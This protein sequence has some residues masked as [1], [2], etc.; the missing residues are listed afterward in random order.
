MTD[1]AAAESAFEAAAHAADAPAAD[2]PAKPGVGFVGCDGRSRVLRV[3][4]V[5][6]NRQRMRV[7]C[8]HG[9]GIHETP[10]SMA[11]PLCDGEPEPELIEIPPDELERDPQDR[12]SGSRRISD[13]AL[14]DAIPVGGDVVVREVAE[15]VGYA[16]TKAG[17]TNMLARLRRM[18]KRSEKEGAPPPFVIAPGRGPRPALVRRVKP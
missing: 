16:K 3:R 2:S 1:P 8:P 17:P 6:L 5:N 7:E 10:K 13:R 4:V 11:R 12:G 18:N 9:C 14:F 15:K